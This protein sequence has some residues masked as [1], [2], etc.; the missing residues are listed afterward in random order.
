MPRGVS[1]SVIEARR[2]GEGVVVIV[3]DGSGLLGGVTR[4]ETGVGGCVDTHVL[5]H[6]GVRR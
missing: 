1:W 6:S 5:T 4:E 3:G 2:I